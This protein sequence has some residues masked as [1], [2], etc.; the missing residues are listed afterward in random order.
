[1]YG[2]KKYIETSNNLI[3]FRYL[4]IWVSERSNKAHTCNMM[5]IIEPMEKY[6][7]ISD[8][9]ESSKMNI[10]LHGQSC[11]PPYMQEHKNETKVEKE[12]I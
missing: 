5:L 7:V 1:M 11:I 8:G 6:L 2:I 3:L 10:I 12:R 9:E 4:K